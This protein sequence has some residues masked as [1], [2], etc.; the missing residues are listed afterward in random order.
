MN[1]RN[2]NFQILYFIVGSCHTFDEAYRI[3][4]QLQEEREQA[5]G[6]SKVSKIK[7][8]IKILNAKRKLESG[9]E[10]LRLEGEAELLEIEVSKKVV[11]RCIKAA[12]QELDFINKLIDIIQP[13]RKYKDYPDEEAHQLCQ[14]EE[15]KLNLI[16]KA[17]VMLLTSGT[18]SY[19]HFLTM[20]RHPD[21]KTDIYPE[22]I[23]ITENINNE[24]KLSDNNEITKLIENKMEDR[25]KW[26]PIQK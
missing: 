15:W 9:D 14:R 5:L 17:R 6:A 4:R 13:Y 16:E 3:L 26:L 10:T 1:W 21:F 7:E 8:K 12:E 25:E 2:S 22:I 11:E 18:I 19:D 20:M 24:D 23:R